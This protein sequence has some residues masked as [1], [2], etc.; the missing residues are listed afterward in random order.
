MPLNISSSRLIAAAAAQG[1]AH[2]P[3]FAIF[4]RAL[5]GVFCKYEVALPDLPETDRFGIVVHTSLSAA[6]DAG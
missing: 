2:E 6:N 3:G 4:L 5:S 1:C